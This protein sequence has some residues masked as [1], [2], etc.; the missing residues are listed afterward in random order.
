MIRRI[1]LAALFALL[2]P[3]AAHAS[4]GSLP[5]TF[6]NGV[7]TVDASTTNAN[8]SFLL[9]CAKNVDNTQ[10][11]AS[12]IYASQIIPTTNAQAT[13]GGSVGYIFSSGGT[14]GINAG[15][16]LIGRGASTGRLWI[17]GVT[18]YGFVDYGISNASAFTLGADV[19]ANTDLYLNSNAVGN[20][21]A[22]KVFGNN[23][24]TTFPWAN[25]DGSVSTNAHTESVHI[26][27]TITSNP[28]LANT[29]CTSSGNTFSF[30]T[31]FATTPDCQYSVESGSTNAKVQGNGSIATSGGGVIITAGPSSIAQN[32]TIQ[33]N[34]HCIAGS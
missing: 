28:C 4:C 13:F 16:V 9:A 18:H 20:L 6:T 25:V 27:V 2:A 7:S 1:V 12:G 22:N 3:A 15:D 11:G 26:T 32:T 19:G 17:G 23:G 31:N 10:I 24:A 29:Q 30:L 33:V 34:A 21:H 14:P 5:N 8:N